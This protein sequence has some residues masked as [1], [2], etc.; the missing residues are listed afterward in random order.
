[1]PVMN[2][3]TSAVAYRIAAEVSPCETRNTPDMTD[4]AVGPKRRSWY[5]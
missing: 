1:M 5:S 2:S 3:M 4:R